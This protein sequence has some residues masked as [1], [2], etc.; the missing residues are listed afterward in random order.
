MDGQQ[1]HVEVGGSPAAV[2]CEWICHI[3]RCRPKLKLT[4]PVPVSLCNQP[5]SALEPRDA[6][7]MSCGLYARFISL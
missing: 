1:R 3:P 2:R 5:M 6:E 7:D 4:A